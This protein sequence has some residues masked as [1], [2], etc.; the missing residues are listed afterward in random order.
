MEK[1]LQ[2]DLGLAVWT[3]VTFLVLVWVLKRIAWGPLL[4]T[5]SKREERIKDDLETAK[6]ERE[7][8]ERLHQEV[9]ERLT[10]ISEEAQKKI[11]EAV[12]TGEKERES[13]HRQ[14][15]EEIGELRQR[16]HL[17]IEQEKKQAL[18]E[19]RSQA[20]ELSIAAAAHLLEKNID[21]KEARIQADRF[22]KEMVE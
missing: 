21:E 6:R 11:A 20:A 7:E 10:Q 4:E 1:L 8:A 22:L 12:R 3:V 15:L 17:Q 14:T 13:I 2:P 9:E 16:A 5:I 18:I 19:I